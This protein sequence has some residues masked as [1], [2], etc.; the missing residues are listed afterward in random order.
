METTVHLIELVYRI[1]EILRVNY[2]AYTK[3]SINETSYLF[4]EL[5]FMTFLS[6][7]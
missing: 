2:L 5:L 3:L 6:P 4:E 1:N 7:C